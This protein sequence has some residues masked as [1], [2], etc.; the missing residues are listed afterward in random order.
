MSAKIININERRAGENEV[1]DETLDLPQVAY[2]GRAY[3]ANWR[4]DIPGTVKPKDKN[5]LDFQDNFSDD[6]KFGSHANK[7][8]SRDAENRIGAF[9]RVMEKISNSE[10]L[11]REDYQA[12]GKPCVDVVSRKAA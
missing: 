4:D 8:V 10:E 11:S 5:E 12:L 9:R 7:T 6:D 3:N 2:E 1:P